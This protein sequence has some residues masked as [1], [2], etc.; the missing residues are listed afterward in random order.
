MRS[1][2]FLMRLACMRAK[3]PGAKVIITE[4][5][6]VKAIEAVMDGFEVMVAVDHI[7]KPKEHK[8]LGK[9]IENYGYQSSWG[10][11]VVREDANGK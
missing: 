8:A 3:G 7:L 2:L 9:V 1:L 5:D 6:P 11:K 4:V 10:W